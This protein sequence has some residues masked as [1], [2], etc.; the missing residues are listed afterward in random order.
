[1]KIVSK[2]IISF[3]VFLLSLL[4][5]F[6]FKTLPFSRLWFGYRVFYFDLSNDNSNV[7]TILQDNSIDYI[8]INTQ[9]YPKNPDKVPMII[10][11]KVRNYS[12][13]EL[14]KPFFFDKDQK[15]ELLYVKETDATLT[16]QVL[17]NK[18]IKFGTDSDTKFFFI[19]TIVSVLVL[20]SLLYFSFSKLNKRKYLVLLTNFEKLK[21]FIS[22][23]PLI[24]LSFLIPFYSVSVGVCVTLFLAFTMEVF[25]QRKIKIKQVLCSPVFLLLVVAILVC[26][27]F[28]GIKVFIAF[29]ITLLCCFTLGF[30]LFS[31]KKETV[32]GFN[33]KPIFNSKKISMLENNKM[34]FYLIPIVSVFI[35]A[36]FYVFSTSFTFS[37]GKDNL[38][39]PAPLHYNNAQLDF[40]DYAEIK[41][42]RTEQSLPDICDF[43]DESWIY[44]SYPYRVLS[45]DFN[46]EVNYG[47]KIQHYEFSKNADGLVLEEL[48]TVQT[49]DHKYFTTKLNEF[50]NYSGVEKLLSNQDY[51]TTIVYNT[52]GKTQSSLYMWIAV[53]TP[54]LI[55]SLIFAF[56]LRKKVTK[57]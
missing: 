17:N 51:Y 8:S 38:F 26:F 50:K 5:L 48:K 33:M 13:T 3:S 41:S 18:K 40:I 54:L 49:F 45:L 14:R 57:K 10:P 20:I 15:Y 2:R 12:S 29:V 30:F 36:I 42:L 44:E 46:P 21:L 9:E 1:M 25:V 19:G 37:T 22:K 55:L 34:R 23:L 11:F 53:C 47:D 24:L 35:L 31:L 16:A 7:E 39:L 56:I 43:I 4:F 28:S 27:I 6:S 52:T 32:Y